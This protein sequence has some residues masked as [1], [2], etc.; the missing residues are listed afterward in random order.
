MLGLKVLNKSLDCHIELDVHNYKNA[1]AICLDVLVIFARALGLK[2]EHL[3][4][5]QWSESL[6]EIQ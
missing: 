4:D 3:H 5:S 2:W 6:L 1:I